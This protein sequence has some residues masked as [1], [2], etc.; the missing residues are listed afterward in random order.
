MQWATTAFIQT[1]GCDVAATIFQIQDGIHH[2]QSEQEIP[3]SLA[4]SSTILHSTAISCFYFLHST[5][6]FNSHQGDEGGES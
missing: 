4:Y 5:F 6:S 3:G 1:R 2:I